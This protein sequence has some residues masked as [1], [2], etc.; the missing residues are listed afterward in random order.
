MKEKGQLG[1]TTATTNQNH[2]GIVEHISATVH[3][4]VAIN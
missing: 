3:L 4:S 1:G 2:S